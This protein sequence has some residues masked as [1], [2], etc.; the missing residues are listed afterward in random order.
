M[1][2]PDHAPRL[3]RGFGWACGV[4]PYDRWSAHR[5][6]HGDS[7]RGLGLEC[8]FAV[9]SPRFACGSADNTVTNW[10]QG[11][12]PTNRRHCELRTISR[13]REHGGRAG[14]GRES[15]AGGVTSGRSR[16]QYPGRPPEHRAPRARR[17]TSEPSANLHR[18][19]TQNTPNP[20]IAKPKPTPT[21]KAKKAKHKSKQK[22]QKQKSKKTKHTKKN[23]KKNKT[24]T[25]H[26]RNN[27]NTARLFFLKKN[28]KNLASSPGP[29]PPPRHTHQKKK[30]STSTSKSKKKTYAHNNECPFLYTP[31]NLS[32][33]FAIAVLCYN[34]VEKNN[35]SVHAEQREVEGLTVTSLVY[36]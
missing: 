5:P 17:D 9:R 26:L 14:G 24:N 18:I 1:I 7:H 12:Q 21:T 29:L 22:A 34:Q 20:P 36:S 19:H 11:N 2:S 33:M 32:R 8:N 15:R 16:G 30:R 28:E 4:K 27:K 3:G 35:T 13:Q 31:D 6:L 10:G 25:K 23:K